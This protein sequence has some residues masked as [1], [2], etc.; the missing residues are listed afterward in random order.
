[1]AEGFWTIERIDNLRV[2]YAAGDSARIIGER[3]GC[4]RNAVI[5]KIHRLEL[6]SPVEK[7]P[8]ERKPRMARPKT[9]TVTH[10]H[11]LTRIFK[12]GSAPQG[13]EVIH[14]EYKL[15]C[16][17]VV[18]LNLTLAELDMKTQCHY[19]PGDDLLYCG[20]PVHSGSSYCPA[21]HFLVWVPPNP[22]K[23]KAPAREAA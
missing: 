3:F 10:N 14:A 7:K 6:S 12:N 5:G 23:D 9:A 4:T 8:V 21:H 1:M 11:I 20:H 19:I 18:P 2:W 17:E 22:L 16:V 13:L 15:R